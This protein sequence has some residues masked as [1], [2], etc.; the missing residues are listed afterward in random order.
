MKRS[1][2]FTLIEVLL[3]TLI[4]AAIAGAV[5]IS[6]S[7]ALRARTRAHSRQ[8]AFA[9]VST[10][11]DRVALDAQNLIR[12]GDLYDVRVLVVDSGSG[13][14]EG[15]H[16]E[17]LLFSHSR[18]QA[19]PLS[20]QNEGAAYEVQYRLQSP[21]DLRA[22]GY[23]LWRRADPVPDETSDGGGVATPIV[24][25]IAALSI[26]AF[27]GAEWQPTWDSD[28]DGF[29]HAIRVTAFARG[30]GERPAEAWSRRTVAIDRTPI[31]YATV[32]TGGESGGAP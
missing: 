14:L 31:P 1:D 23:T 11:V 24:Q 28:R 21:A 3:A 16:D 27:D 29:P 12:S 10:A 18:R 7:Q 17:A 19:R 8:E 26:E 4:A 30:D 6:L 15:E 32:S 5:T 13:N 2:G 22:A 25:G 9:R 20:E